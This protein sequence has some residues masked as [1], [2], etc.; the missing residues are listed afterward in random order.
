M[1]LIVWNKEDTVRGCLC[2]H[3]D[4]MTPKSQLISIHGTVILDFHFCT[5]TVDINVITMCSDKLII[6]VDKNIA[7]CVS[8]E[9]V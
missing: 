6:A 5:G 4:L 7:A 8:I 3:A 9:P 2:F 1:P